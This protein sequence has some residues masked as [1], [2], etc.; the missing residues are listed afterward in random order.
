M[1]DQDP[2]YGPLQIVIVGFDSTD[3]L[4]GEAARELLDPLIESEE[5]LG[6]PTANRRMPITPS[7]QARAWSR[8]DL[9]GSALGRRCA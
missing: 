9:P 7:A 4:Q 2:G 8:A 3:Q 5:M 1:S 6:E